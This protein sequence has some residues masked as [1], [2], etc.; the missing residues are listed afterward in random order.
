VYK[1]EAF[2]SFEALIQLI[3]STVSSR[4]FRVQL[5]T[6]QPTIDLSQVRTQK[7]DIHESLAK[8]IQDATPPSAASAPRS[9][10]GSLGD[11]ASAMGSAK[12]TAKPNPGSKQAKIGRNDLCPCGSGLKYKKCG[13]IGAPQHR[14]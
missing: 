11:L 10:Q 8:E 3:E 7:D 13:L 5:Q 6:P 1:K 2:S 9:T 4:I 14:G 12:A